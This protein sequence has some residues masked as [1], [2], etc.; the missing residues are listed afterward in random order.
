[1]YRVIHTLLSVRK[2]PQTKS[3]SI[4]PLALPS[5]AGV[6]RGSK[7]H[8]PGAQK[9][10]GSTML[11]LLGGES[12][13]A[14]R[15]TEVGCL[16][17]FVRLILAGGTSS[18]T[19]E[20][21]RT[22]CAHFAQLDPAGFSSLIATLSSVGVVEIG[23]DVGTQT[24][25]VPA[26]SLALAAQDVEQE[27]RKSGWQK[28]RNGVSEVVASP[29][30]A[31]QEFFAAIGATTS[32]S[33]LTQGSIEPVSQD[34]ES[35]PQDAAVADGSDEMLFDAGELPPS[36]PSPAKKRATRSA[37]AE[38]ERVLD[39]PGSNKEIVAT[40]LCQGDGQAHLTRDY[41]KSLAPLYPL[42]DVERQALLA[43]KWCRENKERRKTLRRIDNFLSLWLNRANERAETRSAVI[44]ADRS[45]NGFGM[46]GATTT[47]MAAPVATQ[48]S[49]SLPSVGPDVHANTDLDDLVDLADLDA[50]DS[51][52]PDDTNVVEPDVA[53][54]PSPTPAPAPSSAGR[55]FTMARARPVLRRFHTMTAEAGV[56]P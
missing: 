56:Q 36:A 33:D 50:A 40:I 21:A 43:A 35:L 19:V 47:T 29:A 52:V 7:G 13:P 26:L 27:R 39:A 1:M 55:Q 20:R 6:G 5:A 8:S 18:I 24:L 37:A 38:A 23:G 17:G 48:V 28:R 53:R 11:A 15:A 34:L 2:M 44:Q 30:Q 46:G 51:V 22:Y 14:L 54:E 16:F 25:E 49:P 31:A 10:A 3:P 45:R 42:V 9:V 12:F 4:A 41:L 32:A